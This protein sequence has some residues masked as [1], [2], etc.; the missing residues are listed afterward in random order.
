M[1]YLGNH[2]GLQERNESDPRCSVSVSSTI[3]LIKSAAEFI[4]IM[5]TVY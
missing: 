2:L 1:T 3:F 4:Y 5:E